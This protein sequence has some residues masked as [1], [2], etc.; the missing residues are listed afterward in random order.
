VRH[1]V[2][3]LPPAGV[4]STRSSGCK[5]SR[6]IDKCI[7]WLSR[8][9]S[10]FLPD[11]DPARICIACSREPRHTFLFPLWTWSCTRRNIRNCH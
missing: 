11:T 10:P 4:N 9:L 2:E 7:K 6:K 5:P 8:S 3:P 1:S